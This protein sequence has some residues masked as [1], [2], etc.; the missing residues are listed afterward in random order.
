MLKLWLFLSVSE[1]KLKEEWYKVFELNEHGQ[2][3]HLLQLYHL[4][5]NKMETRRK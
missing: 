3:L 5:R 1:G 4:M 2:I